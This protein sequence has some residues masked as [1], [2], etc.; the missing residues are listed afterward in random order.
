MM[1]SISAKIVIGKG[2]LW[3]KL[4][5]ILALNVD[6]STRIVSVKQLNHI[7]EDT[8]TLIGAES[9]NTFCAIADYAN[10]I[11]DKSRKSGNSIFAAKTVYP[12]EK[13]MRE[14]GVIIS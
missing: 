7:E 4:P 5:L 10:F 9:N 2:M 13:F 6:V 12:I 11:R 1:N 3:R 14:K 8:A